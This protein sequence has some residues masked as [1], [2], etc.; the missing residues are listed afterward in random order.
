MPFRQVVFSISFHHGIMD[1]HIH[2]L[3]ARCSHVAAAREDAAVGAGGGDQGTGVAGRRS[4]GDPSGRVARNVPD[5]GVGSQ[6]EWQV[7]N[8]ARTAASVAGISGF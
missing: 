3:F 7:A 8:G 1:L 6:V 2:T 4:G 5:C